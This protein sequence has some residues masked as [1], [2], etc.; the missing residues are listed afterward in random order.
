MG[1]MPAILVG[2]ALANDYLLERSGAEHRVA[3]AARGGLAVT[4]A[5][6]LAAPIA[7]MLNTRVI[8]PLGVP[9]LALV[10]VALVATATAPAADW[11]L[12]RVA[13]QLP[14]APAPRMAYVGIECA[15]LAILLLVTQ[16]LQSV[17]GA[18]GWSLGTGVAYGAL[19]ALFASLRPRFDDPALPAALRGP[20]IALVTAG[21]LTLVLSGL[22]GMLP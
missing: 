13:S 9:E 20:P 1:D 19:A 21:L 3:A 2:I 15:M 7:A 11:L 5:L 12:A 16:R 6:V 14:P 4:L 8:A 22:A 18:L 10:L 17:P